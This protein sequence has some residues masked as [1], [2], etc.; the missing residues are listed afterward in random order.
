MDASEFKAG[1][2]G[3]GRRLVRA[4]REAERLRLS[5]RGAFWHHMM[6]KNMES[7]EKRVILKSKHKS[8]IFSHIFRFIFIPYY[9]H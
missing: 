7:M 9:F 3:L 2:L 6:E 5:E 8:S 1:W 4:G